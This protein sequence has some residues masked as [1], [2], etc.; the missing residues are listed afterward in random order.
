MP[1]SGDKGKGRA[2]HQAEPEG[3]YKG[4][5]TQVQ[6]ALVEAELANGKPDYWF[7]L[8]YERRASKVTLLAAFRQHPDRTAATGTQCIT[9]FAVAL[10]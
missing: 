10:F 6:I 9:P 7:W 2:H 8:Q 3:Y 5:P 4:E 1:S